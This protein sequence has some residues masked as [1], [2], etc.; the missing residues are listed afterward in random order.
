MKTF[1][2]IK[3]T[4][5]GPAPVPYTGEWRI[6]EDIRTFENVDFLPPPLVCE[7]STFNMYFG[8]REETLPPVA[9]NI[10]ISMFRS[11]LH[12]LCGEEEKATEYVLNY[13]AHLVQ[14]PGTLPRVGLVFH[15]Q[16]RCG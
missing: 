8:L 3:P 15:I 13:L 10:D 5:A 1:L 12:I 14:F 9:D 7:E 4:A 16:S 11:H 6:R 2:S